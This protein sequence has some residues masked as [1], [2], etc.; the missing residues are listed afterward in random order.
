[1]VDNNHTLKKVASDA[2]NYLDQVWYKYINDELHVIIQFLLLGKDAKPNEDLVEI[3][4]DW[5][6]FFCFIFF[7]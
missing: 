5:V 2:R 1:M 3:S 4:Q 7:S 6:K